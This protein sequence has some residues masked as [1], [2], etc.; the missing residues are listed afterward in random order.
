[1]SKNIKIG[2]NFTLNCNR[3]QKFVCW[4]YVNS[5]IKDGFCDKF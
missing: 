3:S 5:H 2:Q 1:M 4:M